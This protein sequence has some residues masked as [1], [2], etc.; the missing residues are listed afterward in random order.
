MVCFEEHYVKFDTL[1]TDPVSGAALRRFAVFHE[2]GREVARFVLDA[3]TD[4]TRWEIQSAA[5]EAL[6][7]ARRRRRTPVKSRMQ[8]AA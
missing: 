3:N 6:Y 4:L 8:L 1:V 5:R 2:E 7:E